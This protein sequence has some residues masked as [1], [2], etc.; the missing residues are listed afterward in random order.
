MKIIKQSSD[1]WGE[2]PY[3]I[4]ESI[5]WIERA[6]R[7]CYRSEDKIVDGSGQKFVENIWKRG[8]F[9]VIEH[10]NLVLR[11]RE[12][13]TFPFSDLQTDKRI[14]DSKYF[15]FC[16]QD[17]YTYI[18]GSYRAWIEYYNK[19]IKIPSITLDNIYRIF[20]NEDYQVVI[21]SNEIPTELK[22]ITVGFV[23]DRAVTHELVR[24][25]PASYSQ[26]SQRYVR[27]GEIDFI[28]PHW[29]NNNK[30]NRMVFDMHC[31]NTEKDYQYF[32]EQGMKA[33]EA[34]S[35]LPNAAATKI[36]MSATVPE[37]KHVFSLRL[38]VTAYPQIRLLL[39]PVKDEFI[40]EGW[41]HE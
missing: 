22:V 26:E 34:R 32:I 8:H 2:T 7:T 5:L 29:Y 28:E 39:R 4:A 30:F 37:W 38:P 1:V 23:T 17:D 25:R 27:Y 15:N 13:S 36:V 41:L 16:V 31:M 19:F 14:F 6:G 35:I 21:N 18:G 9:P 10:V 20:E 40:K 24:H 11:R 12:K 3:T 33:Q